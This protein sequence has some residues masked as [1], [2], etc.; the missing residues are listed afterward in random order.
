MSSGTLAVVLVAHLPFVRHAGADEVV[1]ERWLFDAVTETF[2][3]VL[4]MLDGLERDR[5][6]C[7]LTLAVSPL[8]IDSL[9]DALLRDR[10]LRHLDRLVELA[11]KEERRTRGDAAL[12]RIAELHLARFYRTRAVFLDEWQQDVVAALRAYQERGLIDVIPT[13][14]THGL[15]PLLAASPAAIRAQVDVAAAEHRRFFGRAAD[16]LWLPE[17]AWQPGLD[18]A[19]AR[20]GFRYFFVETDGIAHATPRPVY[21]V[22]API[23]CDS[24]VAAFGRDPESAKPVWSVEE[25]FPSDPWYLDFHRDVGFE[26]E[27]DY[28]H[29]YV[30]PNGQRFPTGIKYHRRT[31][32]GAHP[33]P[34]DPD[35]ARARAHAH[36]DEFVAARMRQAAWLARNMDRPP[37]IVCPYDAALFGHRWFEGPLWLDAVLRR[38][39]AGGTLTTATAGDDLAAHPRVQRATPAASTWGWKGHLEPWLGP[40]NDWVYRHLHAAADRLHALARRYPSGDERTRRALTQALRELLLAQTSDWAALMTRD[41]TADYAVRRVTEHLVRCTRLCS[42]VEQGAVDEQALGTLEGVDDV[43]PTLDYRVLL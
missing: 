8:L 12:H 11:E 7:R 1:Q 4:E 20:A 22:Y 13:A 39:A 24:G 9:A 38:L 28:V 10:Y 6:P 29:A 27:Y 17:C 5:V 33:E 3:P 42:E 30:A 31:G 21:G 19:L 26:R 36:A 37:I 32:P 23:V 2:V 43:F 35:R 18:T 25:G 40:A 14:A 34:Y 15:L 41:A 16:G